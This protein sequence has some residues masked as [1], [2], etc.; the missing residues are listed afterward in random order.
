[1][2]LEIYQIRPAIDPKDLKKAAE[3]SGTDAKRF[4]RQHDGEVILCAKDDTNKMLGLL[5][6]G[7]SPIDDKTINITDGALC[8]T[9]RSPQ[10]AEHITSGLLNRVLSLADL[11]G[12]DNIRIDGSLPSAMVN[13]DTLKNIN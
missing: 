9:I 4:V 5:A 12:R 8:P 10:D 6:L 13:T 11:I 7:F 2:N 1:M 3:L